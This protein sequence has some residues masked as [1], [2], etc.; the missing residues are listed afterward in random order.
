MIPCITPGIVSFSKSTTL[1]TKQLSLLKIFFQQSRKVALEK[2]FLKKLKPIIGR[3]NNII[4]SCYKRSLN[5]R[6][7]PEDNRLDWKPIW[8]KKEGTKAK[9]PQESIFWLVT[10]ERQWRSWVAIV[11]V[12]KVHEEVRNRLNVRRILL[13]QK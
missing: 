3:E 13:T 11:V 10:V 8:R 5:N 7:S 4:T 1:I 9:V 2:L 12:G 6:L